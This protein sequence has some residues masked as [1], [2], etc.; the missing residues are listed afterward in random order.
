MNGVI[1]VILFIIG[2]L[3]S[4]SQK[5]DSVLVQNEI[6]KIVYSEILE[7]PKYIKYTVKCPDGTASRAGMDFYKDESIH[8][9]NDEDYEK[10]VWDKGH[11]APAADFNCTREMLNKTFSYVNCIL[12][13]ERLNR[14]VWRLL[15]AH[16]R[17][18]AKSGDVTVEI[19]V[20]FSKKSVKL[21]TG[22]TIP[23]GFWKR[24]YINGKLSECYYF[25]NDIPKEPDYRFYKMKCKK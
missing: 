8:T 13:H 10:N 9:S 20:E 19:R 7:Q 4:F 23:D 12:Q 18:L 25:N 2:T 14:G 11:C 21:P 16:E 15:E 22:A 17:E 5:R 24:I 3:S 1:V 6:Y